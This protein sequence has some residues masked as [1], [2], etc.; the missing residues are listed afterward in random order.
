MHYSSVLVV[1]ICEDRYKR[2]SGKYTQPLYAMG[3]LDKIFANP[4]SPYIINVV[5]LNTKKVIC[6]NKQ[7]GSEMHV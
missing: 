2:G 7:T 6:M 3:E 1:P 5:I 4:T